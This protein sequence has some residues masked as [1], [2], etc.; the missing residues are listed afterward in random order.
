MKIIPFVKI[1]ALA[2]AMTAIPAFAVN[3]TVTIKAPATALPGSSVHVSI[4]ATTDATDAEQ[5]GFFHA[6]Y[7]T[8]NGVTWQS[9]YAEKVGRT[10]TRAI[11]FKA[12]PAGVTALVRVRVA[13]RGGKAGDVD[14]AGAPIKWDSSWGKWESPPTKLAAIAVVAP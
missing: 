13:F 12:G 8:D 5:I 2:I 1:L 6:E 10:A 11:D 14:Y 3:R 7:S 9:R 4:T